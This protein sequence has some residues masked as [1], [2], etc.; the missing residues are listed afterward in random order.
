V[1]RPV[2]RVAEN[3]HPELLGTRRIPNPM[4]GA[5]AVPQTPRRSNSGRVLLKSAD[6]EPGEANGFQEDH[7]AA[8]TS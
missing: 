3:G 5:L 8:E 6:S 2:A 4:R 7:P 1:L